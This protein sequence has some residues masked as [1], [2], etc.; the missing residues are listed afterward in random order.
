MSV[1][2]GTTVII[3]LQGS[4]RVPK[5][6][7]EHYSTSCVCYVN[8]I[9]TNLWPLHFTF[10][11]KLLLF[12]CRQFWLDYTLN[13]TSIR[14]FWTDHTLHTTR[15]SQTSSLTWWSIRYTQYTIHVL[16]VCVIPILL[17][18]TLTIFTIKIYCQDKIPQMTSPWSL[19]LLVLLLSLPLIRTY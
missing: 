17:H 7:T 8:S 3:L 16:C 2:R 4:S 5:W 9:I 1:N 14:W 13:T 15:V 18:I 11:Q 10:M 6:Q 12:S 19:L